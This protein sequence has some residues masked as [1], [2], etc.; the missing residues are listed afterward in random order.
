MNTELAPIFKLRELCLAAVNPVFYAKHADLIHR[1]S[2]AAQAYVFS[3]KHNEYNTYMANNFHELEGYKSVHIEYEL[4]GQV[5][6]NLVMDLVFSFKHDRIMGIIDVQG[7][8]KNRATLRNSRILGTY[9]NSDLSGIPN[10][11][12]KLFPERIDKLIIK[13]E[14]HTK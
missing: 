12:F 10:S 3:G 14:Q 8:I 9:H 11:V 2:L 1:S 4:V 5:N 6:P 13:A 7:N